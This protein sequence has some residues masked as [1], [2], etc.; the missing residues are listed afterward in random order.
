MQISPGGNPG[1]NQHSRAIEAQQ[2]KT[3]PDDASKFCGCCETLLAAKRIVEARD[4]AELIGQAK[5]L[6]RMVT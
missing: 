6:K 2:P 5:W 1:R 3:S 4:A